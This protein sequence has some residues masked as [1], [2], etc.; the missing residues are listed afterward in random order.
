MKAVFILLL[1]L[2]ATRI[3]AAAPVE[4]AIA[5][6]RS[7]QY[8]EAREAFEHLLSAEPQNPELHYYL[9]LLAQKRGEPEDAILHL[10]AAVAAAPGNADYQIELGGAYGAAASKASLLDKLTWAKKCLTALQRAVEL[11]PDSIAAR[12]ALV[13][14]YREAPPIAGGG[15]DKAYEQA[16]E[17]RKRDV[18]TGSAV[19][20]QLY[21]GARRY[22][23]AFE[24]YEAALSLHPDNYRLLYLIGRSAAESGHQLERGEQVL[25]RCL[26]LP[27]TEPDQG[28]AAVHWRLGHIAEKRNDLAAARVEYEAALREHPGFQAAADSLAN[29][30]Q[31]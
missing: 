31:N 8:P 12:N 13:S 18:V 17:I 10:E 16:D 11:A 19:L 2:A 9:G 23:D 26:Q 27:P 5:L 22:D 6:Y 20:G 4:D 25:R 14:F 1:A 15:I 29:L 28:Y 24:T 7:K 30:K 3:W 21:F